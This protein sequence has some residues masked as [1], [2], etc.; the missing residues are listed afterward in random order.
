[1]RLK[2]VERSTD[3]SQ[4]A[5]FRMAP[6]G[7]LEK[8]HPWDFSGRHSKSAVSECLHIHALMRTKMAAHPCT[9]RSP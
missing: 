3:I 6:L 7:D 5:V 9:A 4:P 8:S 2:R 1:M